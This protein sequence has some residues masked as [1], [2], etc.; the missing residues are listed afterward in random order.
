MSNTSKKDLK[1]FMRSTEPQVVHAP[2]P[3]SFKDAE[4]NVIE[5][6][7][8]VLS[9]AKLDEIN[10]GYRRRTIATDKRGNP[11]VANGE[12]VYRTEK[13]NARTT[14][15]MIVEALQYPDLKD[16]QL[17][18]HYGCHDITEMPRLVF[19]RPDEYQHVLRIVMNALGL[20]DE[21]ENDEKLLEEAKN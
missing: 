21:A 16:P 11:I 2:G 14:R 18:E 4:G 12:V 13:D 17:M 10:D 3:A 8:K 15:H 1:Y 19:S 9:Q 7:I 5:F 6:E 20:G